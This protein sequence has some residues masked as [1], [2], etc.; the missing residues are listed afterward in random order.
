[1]T[2]LFLETLFLLAARYGQGGRAGR[3]AQK[4]KVLGPLG[5]LS[6]SLKYRSCVKGSTLR[7]MLQASQPNRK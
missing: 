1:M 7:D 2:T 6:S 4:K 3:T 5:A